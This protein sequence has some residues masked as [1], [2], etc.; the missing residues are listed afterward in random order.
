MKKIISLFILSMFGLLS[1]LHAQQRTLHKDSE[2][3]NFKTPY[4]NYL[5]CTVKKQWYYDD[6]MVYIFL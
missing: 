1:V 4:S 6:E 5:E 3:Y 2:T